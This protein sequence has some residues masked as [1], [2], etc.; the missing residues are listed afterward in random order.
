[1]G[2]KETIFFFHGRIKRRYRMPEKPQTV[3]RSA[4]DI[5]RPQGPDIRPPRVHPLSRTRPEP[6]PRPYYILPRLRRHFVLP[7][8]A[9][10]HRV[11]VAEQAPPKQSFFRSLTI[12]PKGH[13][14]IWR[15]NPWSGEYALGSA[16]ERAQSG[17]DHMWRALVT[18]RSDRMRDAQY[19]LGAA[20]VLLF[21]MLGFGPQIVEGS[22]TAS[23]TEKTCAVRAV[24]VYC[25]GEYMGMVPSED[26]LEA[27]LRKI[28]DDLHST[29]DMH[30]VVGSN[31]TYKATFATELPEACLNTTLTEVVARLDVQVRAAAILVD[32]QI[33]GYLRDTAEAQ[34]ILDK[35]LEEGKTETEGTDLEIV[36]FAQDV[37]IRET[38][39]DYA[40]V[41]EAEDVYERLTADQQAERVY[42][43]QSGDSLWAIANRYGMGVEDLRAMNP[44]LGK[45]LQVGVQLMVQEP[46]RVLDILTAETVVYDQEVP[47]EIIE[48]KRDNLYTTQTQLIRAGSSGVNRVTARIYRCNGIEQSR[49]ILT[50]EVISQPVA[51]VIAVGTKEPA[52]FVDNSRGDGRYVWPAQG[53]FSSSFGWRWGRMHEGI[54]IANLAGTPIYAADSGTVIYAARKSGYGNFIVLYHGDGRETCY[55][56][57]KDYAVKEGDTVEKGQLIGYMGSTGRSTGNHLHFEIRVNG[58][59]QNPMNFLN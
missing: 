23:P 43:V 26:S 24:N 35:I 19:A 57:L 17:M 28:E 42:T 44:T 46:D 12:L 41:N 54:D 36:G 3:H 47:C 40:E 15:Y 7:M 8:P 45:S 11:A 18:E 32:G 48:E 34:A 4:A 16:E 1:M 5:S 22:M 20:A 37:Q 27:E 13:K 58:K 29:Y 33:Y 14:I 56:H 51:R 9:H 39:I 53:S 30:V 21:A 52:L 49:E 25:E 38:D 55:G 59:P 2:K 31:L 6:M 10:V 50:E